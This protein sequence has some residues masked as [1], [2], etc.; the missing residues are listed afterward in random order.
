[1]LAPRPTWFQSYPVLCINFIPEYFGGIKISEIAVNCCIFVLIK[2]VAYIVDAATLSLLACKF[3]A[4]GEGS[5]LQK[6]TSA[7]LHFNT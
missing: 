6:N 2:I 5:L 4:L 1:M 3:V 7:K